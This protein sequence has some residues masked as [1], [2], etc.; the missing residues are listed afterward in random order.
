MPTSSPNMHITRFSDGTPV[1][2]DGKWH[3][4]P[5]DPTLRIRVGLG[6]PPGV[7][8][9][10]SMGNSCGVGLLDDKSV[11]KYPHGI[12]EIYTKERLEAEH[13]ILSALGDH[14]RLVKY[15]GRTE[16]GLRLGLAANGDVRRYINAAEPDTITLD[17]R[18]R[19]S[20]Q[21]SEA[22]AFIHSRGVIHRD[23]D[24]FNFLLDEELN[25]KLCDFGGSSFGEFRGLGLEECRF[26]LPRDLIATA[27][28]VRSDL[29]ALGSAI[30]YIMTGHDPYDSLPDEEVEARYSCQDFPEVDS[31]AGG[32]VILS[33]W[34]GDLSSAQ[35]VVQALLEARAKQLPSKEAVE[36]L[37]K[38]EVGE[39][40]PRKEANKAAER[41][42]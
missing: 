23:I 37:P 6:L 33:C 7:S 12:D 17:V 42:F 14:G 34:K 5:L 11:L 27:S 21:A 39:S 4:D 13:C 19:W 9:F 28:N 35:E 8:K 40:L 18:F 3:T 10:L 30:Y 38:K 22:L 2:E 20:I 24:P 15:L 26:F 31:V 32:R 1:P 25:L 16:H 41:L 29:F 36:L